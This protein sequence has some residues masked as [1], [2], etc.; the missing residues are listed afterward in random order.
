MLLLD[1]NWGITDDFVTSRVNVGKFVAHVI[2]QLEER[3]DPNLMTLQMQFYFAC[4]LDNMDNLVKK[5]RTD[6]LDRLVRLKYEMF[7]I[8]NRNSRTDLVRLITMIVHYI[9]LVSGMG[10]PMNEEVNKGL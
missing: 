5:S 9:T 3:N 10:N 2:R 8:N 1:P 6:L 4:N 7:N